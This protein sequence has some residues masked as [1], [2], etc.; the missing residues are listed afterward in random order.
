MV[1][2]RQR[3]LR[4]C[5][6]WGLLAEIPSRDCRCWEQTGRLVRAGRRPGSC[7]SPPHGSGKVALAWQAT[8]DSKEEVMIS[9]KSCLCDKQQ[10][11]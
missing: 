9:G 10:L 2:P 6:Q 4:V 8:R 11:R 3:V 1:L 5:S 7:P